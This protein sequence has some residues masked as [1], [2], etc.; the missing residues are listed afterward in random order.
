MQ[1]TLKSSPLAH[2]QAAIAKLKPLRVGGLFMEMGTG[3]TF[4]AI[5]LAALKSHKID[6]VVYLCPV[7][8]K[9]T[10]VYELCKHA[11]TPSVYVFDDKTTDA[12][13]PTADWY[14]CGIESV[15]QSDRVTLA[16]NALVADQTF[17]ILDESD[18]CKNHAAQRTRRITQIC[19]RSKYRLIMTGTAVGEGVEDLYAP[20][21]FL[22]P[23]ILGYNSFYSFAANHL[24]YS[25]DY[26]GMVVNNLRVDY[27]TQ[28]LE[29]YVYQVKKEECLD[30]PKRQYL[31]RYCEMTWQQRTLYGKAKDELLGSVPDDEIDSY[32][33]FRLFTALREIVSGFWNETPDP[34]PQCWQPDHHPQVHTCDHERV[35]LLLSVLDE[36]DSSEPVIVWCNFDYAIQQVINALKAHSIATYY[37]KTENRDAELTRWRTGEARILIA[38]PRCG[39]RGIDLTRASYAIFY[40]NDFPFR[41]RDQA[42]AR[43]HRMGQTRPV[44]YIDLVCERTIDDRIV[45]A[46]WAKENLAQRFKK[47][48]QSQQDKRKKLLEL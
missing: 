26:P 7:D 46:L 27:I 17:V 24:E 5:A 36:I 18:T 8:L 3:K 38:S 35:D 45:K 6:K 34:R 32:T 11:E 43:N 4:T 31:T 40:N 12:N 15:G 9:A 28:R 41:L 47:E 33:I 21:Y 20:L 22:S 39:G 2:Q 13:I 1:V 14:I 19:Q 23:K 44:T 25:E 29:P 10:V 30:L 48:L 16:L 42:E 37:G